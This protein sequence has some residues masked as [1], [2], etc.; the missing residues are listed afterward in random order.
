MWTMSERSTRDVS[1]PGRRRTA[2]GKRLD[3]IRERIK[4]SGEP[5][6]SWEEIDRELAER[7]GEARTD[8]GDD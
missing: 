5:L 2:L 7:R 6:L 8:D 3:E 1:R 4:A